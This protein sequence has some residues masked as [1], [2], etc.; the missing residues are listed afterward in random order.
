VWFRLFH[1]AISRALSTIQKGTASS[2][3]LSAPLLHKSFSWS[4]EF[5][6]RSEVYKSN[7]IQK[8]LIHTRIRMEMRALIWNSYQS[9]IVLVKVEA[10]DVCPVTKLLLC[11]FRSLF[12]QLLFN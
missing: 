8:I 12:I 3:G 6:K 2:V 4:F 10:F 7:H 9:H 1:W 11:V 5:H